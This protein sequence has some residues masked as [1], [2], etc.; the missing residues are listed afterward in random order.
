MARHDCALAVA[1]KMCAK[2]VMLLVSVDGRFS[3]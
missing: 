1:L 3:H 2:G